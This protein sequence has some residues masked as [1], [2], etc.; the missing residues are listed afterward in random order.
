[1]STPKVGEGKTE[2][3]RNLALGNESRDQ[4]WPDLTSAAP[5]RDFEN[6]CSIH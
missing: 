5:H 4:K 3:R 1:M 6:R 2:E